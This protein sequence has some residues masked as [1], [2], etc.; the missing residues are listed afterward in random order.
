MAI[1]TPEYRSMLTRMLRAY[2]R[3]VADADDVDLAQMI[4]LRA[5]LEAA[6]ETA[7]H[8]QRAN[9]ASWADIGRG[10]GTTRQSAQQRYSR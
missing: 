9:G 6:I 1:E 5:E 2:G 8:G 3:R 7:V 10:L 4:E